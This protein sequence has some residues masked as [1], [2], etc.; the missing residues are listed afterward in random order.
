[1]KIAVL[2]DQESAA[3]YRFAGLEVAVAESGSDARELLSRLI[4][5]NDYALIAVNA[6]LLPDPYGAVKKEMRGRSFPVLLSVP[7]F[8]AAVAGDD[9]NAE[10]YVRRLIIQTI[11]YEMKI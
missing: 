5:K 3:G 1:M 6:E 8:R 2:T 9:E 10:A 11:G 4:Q 7:G